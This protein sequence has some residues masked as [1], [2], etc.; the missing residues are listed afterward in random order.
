MR[1][2]LFCPLLLLVLAGSVRA[3]DTPRP[4]EPADVDTLKPRLTLET[5]GHTATILML[6]F[7]VDGRQLVSVGEDHT[8]RFWDVATGELRRTLR[9]ACALHP[10]GGSQAAAL[11]ADR[12]TL[13]LNPR[14]DVPRGAK[15]SLVFLDLEQGRVAR[16]LEV[17]QRKG[18]VV[19]MA[20]SP[21]GQRLALGHL[22]GA[23]V[24]DAAT[25][26]LLHEIPGE[27][28]DVASRLAFTPDG[29]RLAVLIA[30]RV[31]VL[32]LETGRREANFEVPGWIN[33]LTW[34]PDGTTLTV[35]TAAGVELWD[36]RTGT[37]RKFFN[38]GP[39]TS[40][41]WGTD[42]GT[43][44]T[45]GALPERKGGRVNVLDAASGQ[46]RQAFPLPAPGLGFG[47]AAAFSPDGKLVAAAL[48]PDQVIHLWQ[49]DSAR[50]AWTAQGR[51]QPVVG[52][53]W[54]KDKDGRT[55]AWG[56]STNR[57][58]T[59]RKPLEQA[60]DL[61]ELRL[62]P[63]LVLKDFQRAVLSR[64]GITLKPSE[65]AVVRDGRTI[66]GLGGALG[67]VICGTLLPGNRAALGTSFGYV[68]LVDTETGKTL[69]QWL[70]HSDRVQDLAPSPDNRYLLTASRDQTL[71]VWNVATAGKESQLLTLF[72]AGP[73]W[74]VWAP[75]G[76]YA[77]TPGGEK[78]MGWTVSSG[79]GRLAAFYP[80]ERFRKRLYRPDLIKL[81]WEKGSV[82]EALKAAKAEAADVEQ[83]LPPRV[84]IDVVKTALPKVK[85]KAT[86]DAAAKG[87]PVTSLRLLVDGRPLPDGAGVL[88]LKTAQAKA[89]AVWEVELAPGEHELKVLARAPD[90][91]GVSEPATVQVPRPEGPRPRKGGPTLHLLAIGI[92]DY[93]NKDLHL[94]FAAK[95][96]REVADAFKGCAGSLFGTFQGRTLLDD[97]AGRKDVLQVLQD[98]RQAAKSGD[99]V[100]VYFA[101]HGVKEK[102]DFYLLTVEADTTNLVKTAVSGKEL[103]RQ[104]ADV[105]CQVL[106]I[107]DACHSAAG[108]KAFK[109]ATDDAARSLTDDECG[110]AVFCAAMGQEYAQEEKGNGLFTKALV[111]ALSRTERVPYN[112]GD[113]R[114][115]VHHL[116]AFVFDEVQR[117]SKDQQHP[118]LNLPWV[119]QSFPVRRL[120][121]PPAGE[122]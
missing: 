55:I 90:T 121:E 35:G 39:T 47:Q 95:D 20:L 104:L 19:S 106:L 1:R 62:V 46:E 8:V 103:R 72:V 85:V 116:H 42:A 101:G 83:L 32:D 64:D 25:G 44:L 14:H 89:E 9:V 66:D 48:A 94:D 102:D 40:L 109:S 108:I 75:G 69:R 96:A 5:G 78:L 111:Q 26:R 10:L 99:L 49:K 36:V 12:R 114:Q 18:Q 27:A 105:P 81:V 21:D 41:T 17:E 122:R 56:R 43:L 29:Q 58:E 117:T 112:Y 100:V 33:T 91:T 57:A 31:H 2:F 23:Y 60:F 70:R 84:T 45:A 77:A 38:L 7:S 113:G 86:A 24:W 16:V 119:T 34:A 50:L 65:A 51:G 92:N 118:F 3:Q 82:A 53:G 107:L 6:S 71:R 67:K 15:R 30:P 73:D 28:G 61:A 4:D 11:S 68:C 98:V 63:G 79:P 97:K 37:K 76:Y 52:A 80:A 120:A 74:I 22:R 88:D 93:Q 110:V 87:Q 59:D 54:G 13:V 115:Y